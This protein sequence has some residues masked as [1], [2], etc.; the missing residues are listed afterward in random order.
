MFVCFPATAHV[1]GALHFAPEQLVNKHVTI[2][3]FAAL[4]TGLGED[5]SELLE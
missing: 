4:E 1:V 5:T 2:A 3:M